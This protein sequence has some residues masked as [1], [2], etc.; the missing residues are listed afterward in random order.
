MSAPVVIDWSVHMQAALKR[1][2]TSTT[3]QVHKTCS[4]IKHVSSSMVAVIGNTRKLACLS[5]EKVLQ[6]KG[7]VEEVSNMHP[8]ILWRA[9]EGF[10]HQL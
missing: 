10:Q 8:H 9:L 1:M 2:A 5:K 3:R 7:L 4:M 6:C